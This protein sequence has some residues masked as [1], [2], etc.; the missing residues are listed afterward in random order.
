LGQLTLGGMRGAE[1]ENKSNMLLVV[2]QPLRYSGLDDDHDDDF[3]RS[4]QGG[5]SGRVVDSA[6]V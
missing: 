5:A 4:V 2:D 3:R 6:R 1:G